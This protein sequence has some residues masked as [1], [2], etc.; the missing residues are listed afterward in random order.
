MLPGGTSPAN[1]ARKRTLKHLF[2]R[3]WTRH[4]QDGWLLE[5]LAAAISVLSLIAIAVLLSIYNNKPNPQLRWGISLNTIAAVLITIA[6][7]TLV[8]ATGEAISQLKWLK[9]YRGGSGEPLS[10]LEAFDVAS[11]G[12]WGAALLLWELLKHHLWKIRHHL[13]KLR[14]LAPLSSL[15]ATIM[16]LQL[17]MG[18]MIQQIVAYRQR[19]VVDSGHGGAAATMSRAQSYSGHTYTGLGAGE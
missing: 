3:L 16:I 11:R 7:T 2:K 14:H 5:A 15:G 10:H 17:G 1:S 18:P 19:P 8:F 4:V 9:Y 13:W 12:P 6:Q